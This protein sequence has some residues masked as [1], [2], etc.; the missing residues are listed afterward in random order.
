MPFGLKGATQAFQRLIDPVLW[1][2]TFVFVYLDDILVTSPSGEVYLLHLKQVF[3]HLDKHGLIINMARCQFEM[4]VIDFLGHCIFWHG[5][6]P[7]PSKVQVMAEFPCPGSVKVLQEFLGMWTFTTVSSLAFPISCHLFTNPCRLDFWQIKAFDGGKSDPANATILAH[8]NPTV[9]IALTTD[10]SLAVGVV[11]FHYGLW[12]VQCLGHPQSQ[13]CRYRPQARG[14]SDTGGQSR[15]PLCH[16][17]QVPHR[18]SGPSSSSLP[19]C[20]L[21]LVSLCGSEARGATFIWPGFCKD[22]VGP[23]DTPRTVSVPRTYVSSF[24]FFAAWRSLFWEAVCGTWGGISLIELAC[25]L[26]V[27]VDAHNLA[28]DE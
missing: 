25:R 26:W 13:V 5:A 18:S 22:M 1:D 9:S 14:S 4:P 8:C 19:L 7:F 2:L 3:Q 24:C 17:H 28:V 12:P 16:L 23:S 20:S 10:A 11:V 27:A 6:V 15:S 21:T